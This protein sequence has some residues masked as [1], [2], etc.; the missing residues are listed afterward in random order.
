MELQAFLQLLAVASILHATVTP[1][2]AE[3]KKLILDAN[4]NTV[5]HNIPINPIVIQTQLENYDPPTLKEYQEC[6]ENSEKCKQVCQGV[7]D[8]ATCLQR[9]PICPELIKGEQL[10]QGVNDTQLTPPRPINTTNVI[11]LTNQIHNII[12]NKGGNITYNNDNAVHLNQSVTFSRVGG[13]FG[14]GYNN[15]DPC[16]IV[17]RPTRNCNLNKF[18]TASRCHRRRHR[19]CG[20]QCKSRV[21]EA[22]RVRVCDPSPYYEDSLDYDN[23]GSC[24]ETVKYVPYHPKRSSRRPDA[25]RCSYIPVWPFV[26]CAP[27]QHGHLLNCD[28]CLR[29]PY[30][31]ILKNGI[32]LQCSYCFS[33]YG[34]WSNGADLSQQFYNWQPPMSSPTGGNPTF[35]HSFEFDVSDGWKEDMTKC[36]LSDGTIGTGSDCYNADDI[37][38]EQSSIDGPENLEDNYSDYD[39]LSGGPVVR[40]RRQTF[41]RSKYSRRYQD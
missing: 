32:P 29:L 26:S 3:D 17:L 12:E 37:G 14:L 40:R 31:Y 15:T 21:M 22:K 5:V 18:S 27:Q 2:A 41:L 16:C 11:R 4:N 13:Q 8:V 25:G 20:K 34:G 28:Y 10:V 1:T 33:N 30:A 23:A 9:C 6:H 19:V 39:Y 7:E 38:D 35:E 24:H 36:I